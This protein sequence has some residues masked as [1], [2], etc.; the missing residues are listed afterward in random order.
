MEEGAVSPL[1]PSIP[2]GSNDLL[3]RTPDYCNDETIAQGQ[4]RV[5]FRPER[6]QALTLLIVRFFAP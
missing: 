3:A 5:R 6:T 1:G 4:T 2:T